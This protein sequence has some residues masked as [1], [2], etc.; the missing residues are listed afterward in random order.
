MKININYC[1]DIDSI[2][3]RL[4]DLQS[5]DIIDMYGISVITL[6]QDT[7]KSLLYFEKELD[8]CKKELLKNQYKDYEQKYL[9]Y[10]SLGLTE[11]KLKS[12]Y[13]IKNC[14][15]YFMCENKDKMQCGDYDHCMQVAAGNYDQCS[16]RELYKLYHRVYQNFPTGMS[17]DW[18]I[19]RL[20]EATESR[21]Q[22]ESVGCYYDCEKEPD[23]LEENLKKYKAAFLKANREKRKVKKHEEDML[24]ELAPFLAA[25]L[26]SIPGCFGKGA[27]FSG[28]SCVAECKKAEKCEYETLSLLA[29]YKIYEIKNKKIPYCQTKDEILE[30]LKNEA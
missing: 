27:C 25:E 14:F 5:K 19:K 26:L 1:I 22:K 9:K 6:L 3:K 24:C 16:M 10:K 17:K 12:I 8:L 30:E 29:L 23:V 4:E 13:N 15:G 18:I 28:C 2:V 21:I 11:T 7:V 20:K